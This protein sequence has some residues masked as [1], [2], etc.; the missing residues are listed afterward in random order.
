[1]QALACLTLRRATATDRHTARC[2]R[3]MKSSLPE[4]FRPR[5][6]IGPPDCRRQAEKAPRS[7]IAFPP[8]AD[9][10]T[11]KRGRAAPHQLPCPRA[12]DT[13]LSL[14]GKDHRSEERR[15]GK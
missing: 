2:N 11:L 12:A 7:R 13:R 8:G 10:I 3:R 15:V 5:F 6:Q 14:P 9:M 4:G 1:M